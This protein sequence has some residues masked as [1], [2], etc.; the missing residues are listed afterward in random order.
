VGAPLGSATRRR[1]P[2][3]VLLQGWALSRLQLKSALTK[4][5]PRDRPVRR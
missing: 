2:A 1:T 4:L 5:T 3:R